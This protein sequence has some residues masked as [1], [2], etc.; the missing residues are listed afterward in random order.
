MLPSNGLSVATRAPASRLRTAHPGRNGAVRARAFSSIRASVTGPGGRRPLSALGAQEARCSA[1]TAEHARET[2][3]EV[4]LG[5]LSRRQLLPSL[6]EGGRLPAESVVGGKR[7]GIE[8][9]G[10]PPSS[11]GR[12]TYS[13]QLGRT[14]LAGHIAREPPTLRDTCPRS[15]PVVTHRRSAC[16]RVTILFDRHDS[17]SEYRAISHHVFPRRRRLC[18]SALPS[19]EWLTPEPT[20]VVTRGKLHGDGREEARMAYIKP[21]IVDFGSIASHTFTTPSGSLK[22]T[23][24]HDPFGELSD[25]GETELS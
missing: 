21:E 2:A 22:G 23:S 3:H 13:N 14:I 24:G 8:P 5:G 20:E 4:P 6:P 7:R 17:M 11:R 25:H 9:H 16:R 10:R 1:A 12:S 15:T 19:E 18:S